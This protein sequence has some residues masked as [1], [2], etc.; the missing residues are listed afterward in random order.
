M[1]STA[2]QNRLMKWDQSNSYTMAAEEDE[3]ECLLVIVVWEVKG[4]RILMP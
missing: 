2:D 1:L 3:E 4:M